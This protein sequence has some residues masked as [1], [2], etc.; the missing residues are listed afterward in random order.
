[1]AATACASCRERLTLDPPAYSISAV[2]VLD[3]AGNRM[4]YEFRSLR[5]NR[6]VAEDL[7]V[8]VPPAGT[9]IVNPP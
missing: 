5:R 7:F 3:A 4:R 2:E 9:E 6:G 8:I 1:V